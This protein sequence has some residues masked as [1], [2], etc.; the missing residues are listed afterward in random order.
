MEIA[1][2][3]LPFAAF[4]TTIIII[5]IV[6]LGLG[7]VIFFHELGH[8]AVAKWCGVY[9]ERFSIG[10]GRPLL[11]WKWGETE[12]WLAIL[13]LGGYV[14]MLGQDDMDPSQLT[15]E[16]IAE[17][18]RAYSNK[19]V[20]QRMAI[21]S[22]G[23]IMNVITAL[24][25]YA[26][27]YGFGVKAPSAT[28]GV[29]AVGMPAW[30]AGMQ[31]GWVIHE[32]NG[33]KVESFMDIRRIV[34]LSSGD[35]RIK[36]VKPDGSAFDVTVTPDGG[37]TRRRIGVG[38]LMGPRLMK[39]RDPDVTPTVPGTSAHEVASSFQPE[40]QIIRIDDVDT[41]DFLAIRRELAK[42]RNQTVTI[43][44]QRAES[45][46]EVAIEVKPNYF[47]T[48]GLFMDIGEIAA[49]RKG[50]P[51]DGKLLKGD[52]I[53]QIGKKKVGTD[54]NPMRL[55]DL[56]EEKCRERATVALTIQ[57]KGA[58]A[59]ETVQIVFTENDPVL[60]AWSETPG[61]LDS[62]LSIPSLGAAVHMIAAVQHV[63]P[64]SPADKQGIK[65]GATLTEM[66]FN[67]NE[68][69]KDGYNQNK[70]YTVKFGEQ[71]DGKIKHNWVQA[72]WIMQSVPTR[73]V[74]LTFSD[75]SEFTMS[76]KLDKTWPMPSRGFR[77]E[78]DTI[79]L[80]SD[81]T[82]DAIRMAYKQTKDT[83]SDTYLTI[84]RLFD[85]G[86]S[87][88][89]LSGPVKIASTAY[90]IAEQGLPEFLM[91]LGFLSINLAVLNFL[92]IPVLD[93]G[94]MVFLIWE[95][96]TRKKPSEKVMIAAT[97]LGLALVLGLMVFVLYLDIFVKR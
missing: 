6:A 20:P 87:V 36:G 51:A 53:L 62:P 25:F 49:I 72:F 13:P 78:I 80:Q 93:G 43:H 64:G 46:E 35:L 88:K 9:V 17:D 90:K 31:Q 86:I 69:A 29:T 3:I 56:F 47:H 32:I 96:V 33:R 95:A 42:K 19:S 82:V 14:K 11:S 85:G 12:Y 41:P 45:G 76:P 2:P 71:D 38:Y 28:V 89:E 84:V 23:V 59:P 48:L 10:F 70:T 55:P 44:V 30:E 61:R 92:P 91:F 73:T 66:S 74:T 27:A 39:P 77:M 26:V 83:I 68:D 54:I 7:L 24:L 1:T 65:K 5:T 94:H 79:T 58:S 57:R 75:D 8:F 15:S 97:Y 4:L 81:G 50:S 18:P 22:A 60:T 34:A 63:V 37:G 21:I 16:E 52:K 40:D 67:I